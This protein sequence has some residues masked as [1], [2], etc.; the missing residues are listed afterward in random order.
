MTNQHQAQ[1]EQIAKAQLGIET[2]ASR[3][4]DSLDFYDL[5]VGGIKAALEAAFKAGQAAQVQ[6]RPAKNLKNAPESF[7]EYIECSNRIGALLERLN[8]FRE[9]HLAKAT[10]NPRNWGYTGDLCA[11]ETQ[12]A[13]ALERI[14]GS[15]VE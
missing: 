1:I 6:K 12:L 2:L 5:G 3:N 11:M 9:S 15:A 8:T 13:Y 4:S 10:A 7:R 14:G